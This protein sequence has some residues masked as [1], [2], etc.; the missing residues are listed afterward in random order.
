MTHTSKAIV[1]SLSDFGEAD[2]YVSFLTEQWGVISALA[3]SAR[4]SKR[5]YVGG[6]DLFCHDEILL[7]GDPKDRPYLVELTVLNSFGR[8]REDLDKMLAAGQ[9]LQ[10]TRKLVSQTTPMPSVYRLLGQTLALFD[11]EIDLKR[12]ELVTLLFKIKLLNELGLRPNT[13]S[14]VRC[15]SMKNRMVLFDVGAGGMVCEN[16]LSAHIPLE[17]FT[18]ETMDLKFI[19]VANTMSLARFQQLQFPVERARPLTYLFTKFASYH[20]HTKLPI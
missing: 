9:V 2:R 3:K 14:C 6:L 11:K 20:S 7:R 19:E 18:L 16:C 17:S 13:A 8:I 5:R 4:K 10:W 1:L 15:D 12:L